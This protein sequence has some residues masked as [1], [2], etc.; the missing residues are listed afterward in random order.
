MQREDLYLINL[1]PGLYLMRDQVEDH[2]QTVEA[3]L[4]IGIKRKG[5]PPKIAAI[6]DPPKVEKAFIRRGILATHAK[7]SE[8][9]KAR[10]RNMPEQ[11]KKALQRKMAEA[12]LKAK[13]ERA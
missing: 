11:K 5:R 8:S 10:W 12:R 9:A 7:R 3:K 6:A 1:L 2:I 13:A 4:G